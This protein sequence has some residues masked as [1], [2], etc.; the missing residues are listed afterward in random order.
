MKTRCAEL[1]L[2]AAAALAAGGVGAQVDPSPARIGV[3]TAVMG[4]AP[5]T[6]AVPTAEQAP[7]GRW[8]GVQ[9]EQAFRSADSDGN[10]ELTRAEAQR[11]QIL[12]R[13]FEDLDANKDGV[14]SLDEYRQLR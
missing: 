9:L 6:P 14:L 2:C 5:S 10:G 12:P 3:D 4:A 7:T 11:L 1:A 8:T 13:T